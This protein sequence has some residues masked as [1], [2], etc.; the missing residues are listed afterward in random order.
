MLMSEKEG[1]A[2]LVTGFGV[3]V[4]VK[5]KV[6]GVQIARIASKPAIANIFTPVIK[7]GVE[8]GFIQLDV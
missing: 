2:G 5:E 8:L 4:G 7:E 1:V 3:G 6:L